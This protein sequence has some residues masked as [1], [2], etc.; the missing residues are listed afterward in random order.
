MDHPVY[1]LYDYLGYCVGDGYREE[2]G[3]RLESYQSRLIKT[4]GQ[5]WGTGIGD[6][7]IQMGLGQI[8]ELEL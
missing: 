5:N 6:E 4:W 2:D 7:N 8:L 3:E 1:S